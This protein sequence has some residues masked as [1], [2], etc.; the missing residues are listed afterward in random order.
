[1]P[2]HV[3]MVASIA[4]RL[5]IIVEVVYGKDIRVVVACLVAVLRDEADSILMAIISVGNRVTV[6]RSAYF[7]CTRDH[8]YHSWVYIA[9][10][11]PYPSRA[12]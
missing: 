10:V 3:A 8:H 1:M 11:V 5:S 4:V 6:G 12:H 2:E 9:R 7:V